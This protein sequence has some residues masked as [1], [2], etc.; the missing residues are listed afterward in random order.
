MKKLVYLTIITLV[1]S[2]IMI[3]IVNANVD[4]NIDV[5]PSFKVN[6]K[7]SFTYTI[8][9]DKDEEIT[10]TPITACP[11]Y[12]HALLREKTINLQENTP[13]TDTYYDFMVTEEIEPQTCAA[14]V[15]IT[16]PLEEQQEFSKEFKII[17]KPSFKVKVLLCKDSECNN[18]AKVFVKGKPIYIK[19]ITTDADGKELQNVQI[20]GSIQLQQKQKTSQVL[21]QVLFGNKK[22]Q[23]L[24]EK[25]G[26]QNLEITASKEGYKTIKE[27]VPFA[28]IEK[29]A[30]IKTASIC[31]EIDCE[32]K[33]NFLEQIK[34]FFRDLLF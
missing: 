2:L 8:T 9:S 15:K 30:A 27:T 25:I 29:E 4:I 23:I 33:P 34:S 12:P 16:N 24:S 5:K 1:I 10:Y 3:N 14:I 31:D 20:Q 11:N 32:I 6:E 21:Q 26:S 13:Y 19:I 7:T 22:P 18:P 28:I 17:T